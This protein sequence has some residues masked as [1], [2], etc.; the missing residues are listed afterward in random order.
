MLGGGVRFFYWWDEWRGI[1][2]RGVV[3]K[4]GG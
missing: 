3:V 1:G 2:G 4:G